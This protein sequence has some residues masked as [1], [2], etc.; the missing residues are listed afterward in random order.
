MPHV[1]FILFPRFQ[2][3]AYVLATETMRI[4]NKH[5]GGN[6]FTWEARTATLGPVAAS[7]EAVV[8]SEQ[9]DWQ[10]HRR[11]DL[12]LLCAGYETETTLTAGLRAHLARAHMTGAILGGLDT[13][14]VIL[15]RLGYLDGHVAILHHEAQAGFRETFPQIAVS[16][17]IYSFDGDRLTAAGGTATCDAILAWIGEVTSPELAAA[18]AD[19]MAHGT[20]RRPTDRQRQQTSSDPILSKMV[21]TMTSALSE[22]V[23]VSEI[24][25]K[26]QQS[27]KQLRLRCAAGFGKTPSEVYLDLRMQ[28]AVDLLR[29]TELKVQ[30]IAL[31]SGFNSPASFARL[32]RQRFGTSPRDLRRGR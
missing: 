19:D 23:P 16:E 27:P 32:F 9:L 17:S 21:E 31:S 24:A 26:L 25:R 18:T 1:S 28:N 22:P 2:M 20:I 7:N 13:G 8:S 10:E 5:A 6:V 30:E 12:V 29:S 14:T 4:A 11:P 3:L 15:A